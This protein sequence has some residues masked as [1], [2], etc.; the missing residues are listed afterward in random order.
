M[1]VDRVERHSPRSRIRFGRSNSHQQRTGQ[2]GPNGRS[3]DIGPIQTGARQRAAHGGTKRLQVC[4]RSDLR[5][6]AAE[7]DVLVHAGRHLV[8]QQRHGAVGVEAGDADSGFVAGG[9]DGQDYG[10]KRRSSTSLR[11]PRRCAAGGTPTASSLAR[12]APDVIGPPAAWCRR[13]HR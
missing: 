10:H 1:L 6:H 13:P 4:P 5:N 3:D 7:P 2:P 12:L 11:P 8:G 9:F